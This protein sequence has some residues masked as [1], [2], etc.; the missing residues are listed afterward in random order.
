MRAARLKAMGLSADDGIG[1]AKESLSDG[2]KEKKKLTNEIPSDVH[3]IAT[4]QLDQRIWSLLS[5]NGAI[6]DEN[7]SRWLK[8]GFIFSSLPEFPIGLK[9]GPIYALLPS[10]YQSFRLRWA[11]RSSCCCAGGTIDPMFVP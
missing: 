3:S 6:I 9:Q 5:E 8:Q 4:V 2:F 1:A 11:M 10:M 7:M